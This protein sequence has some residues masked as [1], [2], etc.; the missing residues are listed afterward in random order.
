MRKEQGS[1][2]VEDKFKS[3]F[4]MVMQ[5]NN[6]KSEDVAAKVTK[7]ERS[8]SSSIDGVHSENM[9][10]GENHLLSVKQ[11]LFFAA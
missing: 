5:K 8:I 11:C 3:I 2:G 9:K 7:E 10:P 6:W 4:W 1:Q